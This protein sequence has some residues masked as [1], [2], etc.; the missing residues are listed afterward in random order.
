MTI[1]ERMLQYRGENELTQKQLAEMLGI[2][3]HIVYRAE[4]GLGM[5]KARMVSLNKKMD[6]LE[7]ENLK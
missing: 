7:K 3:A 6:E 1:G 2:G 4:A 5:H